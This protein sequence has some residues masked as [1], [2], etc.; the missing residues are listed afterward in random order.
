M[1]KDLLGGFEHRVLLTTLRVQPNAFTATIVTDLEERTGRTVA[2][3]AVYIALKRLEKKGFVSSVS[4]QDADPGE[5][6]K[7][8][9]F[10]VT[11]VG[12]KLLALERGELNSLWEGLER[13][14]NT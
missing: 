4:R 11:E 2:L 8:R 7:R 1:S 14:L 9:Y 5:T 12:K 13:E 3:A 10:E 6:R